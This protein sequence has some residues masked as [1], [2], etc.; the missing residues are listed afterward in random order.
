MNRDRALLRRFGV[1]EQ[2]PKEVFRGSISNF[3]S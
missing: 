3:S 2:I 1:K